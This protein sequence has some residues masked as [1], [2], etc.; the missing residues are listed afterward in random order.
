M[1]PLQFTYARM[2]LACILARL[3]RS[4]AMSRFTDWVFRPVLE[5]IDHRTNQLRLLIMSQLSEA[6][7]RVNAST[8]A[9]IAAVIAKLN[10]PNADVAAAVTS[11][12]AVADTLDAETAVLTGPNDLS[13]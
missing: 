8:S 11:L 5:R 12:Q 1:S 7:A 3:K 6:V 2:I 4:A 13:Q 9:E 10:E